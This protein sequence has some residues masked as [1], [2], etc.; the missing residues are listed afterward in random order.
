MAF[1]AVGF[2]VKP[3]LYVRRRD[4]IALLGGSAVRSLAATAQQ[5][6]RTQG[7]P[8]VGILNYA[9]AQDSLVDDFLRVRSR[10]ALA[11]R[12]S[13]SISFAASAISKHLAAA[14]GSSRVARASDHCL[15][16][17]GAFL[18]CRLS[19]S[20]A[21]A[22]TFRH[23]PSCAWARSQSAKVP[24]RPSYSLSADQWNASFRLTGPCPSGS[25][26]RVSQ[27]DS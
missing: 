3:M 17:S 16:T 22:R 5:P 11:V 7:V 26:L 13:V 12:P 23:A 20:A 1:I 24:G 6:R 4:L 10:A 27:F 19:S 8:H 21:A 2:G 25:S 18:P 14:S 15:A 9:A